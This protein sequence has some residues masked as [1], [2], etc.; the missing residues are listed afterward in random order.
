MERVRKTVRGSVTLMGRPGCT[1]AMISDVIPIAAF[2][3]VLGLALSFGSLVRS[4]SWQVGLRNMPGKGNAGDVITALCNAGYASKDDGEIRIEHC[5]SGAIYWFVSTICLSIAADFADDGSFIQAVKASGALVV[6][7]IIL[8]WTR[9]ELVFQDD[10]HV[11]TVSVVIRVM[12]IRVYKRHLEDSGVRLEQ[13]VFEESEGSVRYLTAMGAN[14]SSIDLYRG[15]PLWLPN[16]KAEFQNDMASAVNA[17]LM[18]K[19]I[20]SNSK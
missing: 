13:K 18:N 15:N 7:V 9:K 10:G 4:A 5:V 12:G 1:N 6:F 8:K 17:W 3:L 2:V 19:R 16:P 14:G 11:T 20:Q